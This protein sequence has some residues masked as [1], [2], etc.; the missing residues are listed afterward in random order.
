M[1]EKKI[2]SYLARLYF[3][4]FKYGLKLKTRFLVKLVFSTT[5]KELIKINEIDFF[6]LF[7]SLNVFCKKLKIIGS[8]YNENYYYLNVSN[9]LKYYQL[10]FIRERFINDTDNIGRFGIIPVFNE[11]KN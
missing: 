2:N 11:I 9:N 8:G 4:I 10:R 6:E 5:Y 3:F 1:R 7:K